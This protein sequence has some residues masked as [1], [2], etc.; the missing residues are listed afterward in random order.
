MN[1]CFGSLA[2]MCTGI[3]NVRKSAISG[4]SPRLILLLA[5]SL[6]SEGA[7]VNQRSNIDRLQKRCCAGGTKPGASLPT[8]RIVLGG[9]G[10]AC[11]TAK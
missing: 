11:I 7:S 10:D 9:L 1:V 4:H 6:K 2:D 5:Q 3:S 8:R